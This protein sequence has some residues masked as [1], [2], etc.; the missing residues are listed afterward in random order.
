M[1]K[2]LLVLAASSVLFSCNKEKFE[3]EELCPKVEETNVPVAAVDNFNAKHTTAT[4]TVWFSVSEEKYC[5]VF[6][7]D[8]KE[9]Y[10]YYDI[11]GNYLSWDKEKEY[12]KDKKEKKCGFGKKKEYKKK[13]Y[14]KGCVCKRYEDKK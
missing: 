14:D 9:Q 13:K 2:I 5:V 12:D 4:N 10:A 3:K 11:H 7:M 8:G 6:D 1:R